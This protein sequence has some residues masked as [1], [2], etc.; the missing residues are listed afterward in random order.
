[1]NDLLLTFGRGVVKVLISLLTGAGVGLMTFGVTIRSKPELWNLHDP[2]GE[3]FLSLGA[4]LLT[5]GV[6]MTALF[7]VPRLRKD[8]AETPGKRPPAGAWSGSD[9]AP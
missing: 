3:L 1:M 2:P 7:L 8:R 9:P 5:T 4:G 6:L